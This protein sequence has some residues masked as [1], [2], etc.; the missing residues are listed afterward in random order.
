MS[1]RHGIRLLLFTLVVLLGLAIGAA[2]AQAGPQLLFTM[3]LAGPAKTAGGAYYFAFTVDDTIL[4]GPQSD[5]SNWTH[6]IVFR[7]GRFF[8]GRVPSTLLRPFEFERLR[9]PEPFLFGQV[10][11]DGR[12]IRVQ[13]ALSDLRIAPALPA[14]VKVNFVT[15]DE[16]FRPIDALGKDV[17]DRLGFA[18]LDLRR[19]TYLVFSSPVNKAID[20]S[21][22]ILGGDIQVTTP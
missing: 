21:F 20:P 9:P 10:L 17:T 11:P 12:A 1:A 15:V 4:L 13:V 16:F 5:G 6:Y 14:Q 22:D 2:Y 18:T 3:N 8:F 7:G 19:D